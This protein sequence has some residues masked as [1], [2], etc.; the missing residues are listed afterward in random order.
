[1][2]G[3]LVLVVEERLTTNA[4]K[5]QGFIR[6]FKFINNKTTDDFLY[7]WN[8]HIKSF[9]LFNSFVFT[10]LRLIFTLEENGDINTKLIQTTFIV[11]LCVVFCV[12]PEEHN[13]NTIKNSILYLLENIAATPTPQPYFPSQVH[14]ASCFNEGKIMQMHEMFSSTQTQKFT[15]I[16]DPMKSQV[17]YSSIQSI[18]VFKYSSIQVLKY[19]S[20]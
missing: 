8:E 15:K 11:V 12:E 16:I 6:M 13:C 19:S 17:K 7:Q 4:S 2:I 20:I 14:A 10:P 18:Q 9:I 3:H 5:Q 1:M